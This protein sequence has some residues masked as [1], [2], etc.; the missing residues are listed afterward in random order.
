MAINWYGGCGKGGGGGILYP[1]F[2]QNTDGAMTQKATTD[3]Y[4]H[5]NNVVLKTLAV[6]D[7]TLNGTV[8]EQTLTFT[9]I[10]DQQPSMVPCGATLGAVASD[11]QYSAA[12]E[13]KV[14][15][16]EQAKTMTFYAAVQPGVDINFAIQGVA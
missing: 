8:Y 11:A 7:W 6:A 1:D 16:D 4:N 12:S 9:E 2:G 3:A 15:G 10:Y 5:Y 13:L 14:V